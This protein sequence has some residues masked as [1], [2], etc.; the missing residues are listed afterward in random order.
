M[1]DIDFC[2]VLYTLK[3][4]SGML[5]AFWTHSMWSLPLS[6]WVQRALAIGLP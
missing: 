2:G 1:S 6:P 3:N 4:S 5:T